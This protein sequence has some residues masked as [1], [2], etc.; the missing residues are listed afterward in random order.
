MADELTP[1]AAREWVGDF[2]IGKGRP[3]VEGA[4]VIGT[5]RTGDVLKAVV[6]GTRTRPYLV[7]VRV[8]SGRV[9]EAVCIC[10]VGFEGKCK[11]VAAVLLAYLDDPDRFPEIDPDA[12]LA[13]RS[14][15]ELVALTGLLLRRAPQL[16]SLL[17]APLPGFNAPP[18]SATA[19]RRQAVEVI[20]SVNPHNDWAGT[21]IATGLVE[22]LELAAGFEAVA[23]WASA[24]AV[25]HGVAQAVASEVTRPEWMRDLEAAVTPETWKKITTYLE[26]PAAGPV[27]SAPF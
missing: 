22:I 4:A 21:E 12:D 18:A 24:D 26:R 20:R 2:E 15:D 13:R 6:R 10:P 19:Y 9:D 7:G 16:V 25:Y 14:K 1:D 8:A 11:H 17:A 27:E 3:Y 23:E 5:Y